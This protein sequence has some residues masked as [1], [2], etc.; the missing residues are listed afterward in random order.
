MDPGS[1]EARPGMFHPDAPVSSVGQDRFGHGDFVEVL[2]YVIHNGEAPLNIALYGKWGVGKSSI[3][4]FFRTEIFKDR[5]LNEKFVFVTIDVWKLSPRI[6]KQ[7]FLEDLNLKL[8]EPMAREEIEERLWHHKEESSEQNAPWR[9]KYGWAIASCIGIVA[10]LISASYLFGPYFENQAVL[11]SSVVAS[12]IPIFVV[13]AKELGS[14]SKSVLKS[15]KTF[16]PRIE[17]HAQFQKLFED[18][19]CK[20]KNG[21]KPIIAIDNLDRCDDESVVEILRMIKTF[22]DDPKCF[23]I[24]ACDQDAI[25][26]HLQ[27]KNERFDQRYAKEFLGKFFQ[28]SLYIPDQIKGQL[29]EYAKSQLGAFGSGIEFDPDVADIFANAGTKNPRKIRQFVYSFA[30]AYKMASIKEDEG[31][32]AKGTVT[33]N[34]PFLAKITVLREDW[35]DFF[36]KLEKKPDLLNRI[37]EFANSFSPNEV[38]QQILDDNDG[39]GRFLRSTGTVESLQI[40]TFMQLGQESFE[41]SL[42][43]LD[44]LIVAVNLNDAESVKEIVQQDP[45]KQY[46]C[47]LKLCD[48]AE[49]YIEDFR[50]MVASYALSMLV[51]LYDAVNEESK[52]KIIKLLDERMTSTAALHNLVTFDLDAVFSITSSLNP[53]TRERIYLGYTEKLSAS[54][55]GLLILKK[56][57]DKVSLLSPF[58]YHAIDG[59]LGSWAQDQE[60]FYD[61]TTLLMESDACGRLIKDGTLNGI[62]N[63]IKLE[64]DRWAKRYLELRHLASENTKRTFIEKMLSLVSTKEGGMMQSS[65]RKAYETLKK[66]TLDDFTPDTAKHAYDVLKGPARHYADAGDKA[67]AAGIVLKIYAKLDPADREEFAADVFAPLTRQSGPQNLAP[68]AEA[69]RKEGVRIL[70]LEAAA[71]AVFS[72]LQNA[73]SRESVDLMYA[74]VPESKWADV[75]EEIIQ[76]HDADFA[77]VEVL[78]S[79]FELSAR[80]PEELRAKALG[81]MAQ[82]C[83]RFSWV[84]QLSIHRKLSEKLGF[85]SGLMEAF[86][87]GLSFGL[88]SNDRAEIDA[89]MELAGECLGKAAETKRREVF[90]ALF[91]KLQQY[92]P[93]KKD[94]SMLKFLMSKNKSMDQGEKGQLGGVVIKILRTNNNSLIGEILD[95]FSNLDLGNNKEP[96]YEIVLKLCESHDQDIKGRALKIVEGHGL[97]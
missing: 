18:M 65:D 95:E 19:V 34:T 35:P 4:E 37:Q 39:L 96:A 13:M 68:L 55:S 21:K 43:E 71:D 6:L 76:V 27:R 8:G 75:E 84:Q 79:A 26:K 38:Y 10:G 93:P 78:A 66:L 53:N 25:I 42:S 63:F 67:L 80:A 58:L 20:A 2:K 91:D 54:D 70:E 73:P 47:V 31:A 72:L 29:Y 3:L 50:N 32:I 11:S 85:E 46:E 5:D 28:V 9:S 62:I 89:Y 30:I 59:K 33:G 82:S 90:S 45:A 60:L 22:L 7:E 92:P 77:K 74:G 81:R 87:N 94:P 51:N 56:F 24:V 83:Q 86:A 17:S 44:R 69:V 57:I 16:I 61:A 12:V 48:L 97:R 1:P 14:L 52:K 36:Q 15:R 41:A 40:R 23:F 64:D 88:G 49:D